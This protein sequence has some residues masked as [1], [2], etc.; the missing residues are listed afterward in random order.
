MEGVREERFEG[1]E[2]RKKLELDMREC[3]IVIHMSES[4]FLIL[5]YYLFCQRFFPFYFYSHL[6]IFLT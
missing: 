1:L 2:Y 5:F 6:F 4:S 3:K